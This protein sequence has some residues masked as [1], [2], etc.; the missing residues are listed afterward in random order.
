MFV[1]ATRSAMNAPWTASPRTH[2]TSQGAG[3]I[4]DRGSRVVAKRAI[5]DDSLRSA[6]TATISTLPAATN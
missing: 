1:I 2:L 3:C 5:Q 6:A 4:S